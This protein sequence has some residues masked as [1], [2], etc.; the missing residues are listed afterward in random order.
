MIESV[1]GIYTMLG[2]VLKLNLSK[3]RIDSLC[4]LE[5][6]VA[7]ERIDVRHNQIV[8]I[9]EVG[10]LA[11]LPNI[12]QIWIEGNDFVHINVDYRVTVFNQFLKEG[13]S[14]LM[15]G[16]GPSFMERRNL[17]RP[18]PVPHLPIPTPSAHSP[19]VVAVGVSLPLPSSATQDSFYLA[20]SALPTSTPRKRK[21]KRVVDLD[22]ADED[23]TRGRTG[24]EKDIQPKPIPHAL[25]TSPHEFSSSPPNFTPKSPTKGRHTRTMTTLEDGASPPISPRVR[26]PTMGSATISGNGSSKK[27]TKINV[28]MYDTPRDG[29]LEPG[30]P[31]SQKSGGAEAFKAEI[32]AL[33]ASAP[34]NWLKVLSQ[35]QYAQDDADSITG[36]N[37]GGG[38]TKK[39][40]RHLRGVTEF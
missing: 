12:S 17:I 21:P 25:S 9:H 18:P 16:T 27:R 6:L 23:I 11:T 32:E 2:Q 30:L 39:R 5:R 28:A 40:R 3:N 1:L 24:R 22:A 7:L 4:G 31:S 15:D 20:S 29:S 13:K 10:R 35:K 8:D 26:S 33:R 34:D 36:S 14:I 37:S 38:E 19:P